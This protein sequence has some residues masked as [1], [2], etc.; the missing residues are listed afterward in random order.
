MFCVEAH[1]TCHIV[2]CV[3]I[4][5]PELQLKADVLGTLDTPQ[6]T[7]TLLAMLRLAQQ[8]AVAEAVQQRLLGA[9][10]AKA[11]EAVAGQP[12]IATLQP[13]ALVML[14]VMRTAALSATQQRLQQPQQVPPS[15][16][17]QLLVL[18]TDQLHQQHNGRHFVLG[19]ASSYIQ[20]TRRVSAVQPYDQC[21]S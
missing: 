14:R 6:H 8:L 9:D 5:R 16:L 13:H 2:I 20:V 1:V 12:T 10:T 4:C 21:G 18:R 7:A 11:K 17:Q 15:L 3:V 19:R